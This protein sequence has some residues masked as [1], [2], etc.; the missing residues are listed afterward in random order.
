MKFIHFTDTH[1]VSP[2][3]KIYGLDPLARL[4]QVV[5]DFT[6]GATPAL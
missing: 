2:G 5:M 3:E 1:L 4:H 6:P